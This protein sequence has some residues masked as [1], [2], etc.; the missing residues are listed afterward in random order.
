MTVC[1]LSDLTEKMITF[2]SL[3]I[4]NLYENNEENELHK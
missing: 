1:L 4:S 3:G 2:I